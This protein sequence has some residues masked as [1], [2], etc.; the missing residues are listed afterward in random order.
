MWYPSSY[1]RKAQ[2]LGYD[3]V[4]ES[5]EIKKSIGYMSQ[6]FSL[7]SDLTVIENITFYAKVYGVTWRQRKERIDEVVNIVGIKPYLNHYPVPFLVD[8]SEACSCLCP[9]T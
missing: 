6:Q 8:G 5:E 3:V 1:I 9:C 4:T 2:V 7:Y